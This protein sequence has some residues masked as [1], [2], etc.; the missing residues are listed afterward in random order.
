MEAGAVLWVGALR[1]LISTELAEC[2]FAKLARL[3]ALRS[4]TPDN[5]AWQVR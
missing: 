4:C 5:A 3:G 1:P 2:I